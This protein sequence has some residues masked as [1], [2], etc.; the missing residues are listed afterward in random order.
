[1]TPELT[2]KGKVLL[3]SALAGGSITFTK[4]QFGNGA[5][6]TLSDATALINPLITAEISKITRAT[7]YVTLTTTLSNGTVENGFHITEVGIFAKGAGDSAEE[8]LYAL[9][10]TSESTA[11]YVPD[12]NS[13]IF[14]MQFDALMF[15]GTATN[16]SAAINESLV[17][18]TKDAFDKHTANKQ[19]PHGVTKEQIGLGNVANLAISDQMP[20][21]TEASV[22]ANIESGEKVSALFGK[23]KLAITN[24]INHISN[25][26]NPHACTAEKIGAAPTKHTHSASDINTGV[27]SAGR[28]GLGI[29]APDFG[30][31]IF[32]YDSSSLKAMDWSGALYSYGK[33]NP[34]SGILP[35]TYGG[36]GTTSMQGLVTNLRLAG[37]PFVDTGTYVGDGTYN[38]Q[39]VNSLSFGMPP[40]LLIV[41]STSP[42]PGRAFG[43]FIWIWGAKTAYSYDS[44]NSVWDILYFETQQNTISWYSSYSAA[45]QQNTQG[46]TYTYFAIS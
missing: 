14:E 29:S 10:N 44:Q 6:Q 35:V 38:S 23:I 32:G 5:S 45:T 15:V 4:I 20:I 31:A 37:M 8:V 43:E 11:D 46:E 24:L 16:V 1:M 13:R 12:K 39:H 36:T 33:N 41:T 28:G 2:N 30:T 18:A 34:R 22:S 26:N 21:F 19:N 25:K 9:G 42:G 40:K 27:L 3:V 7:D 17:Y